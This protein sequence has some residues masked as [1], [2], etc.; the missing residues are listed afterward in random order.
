MADAVIVDDGG[1]T[2]IKQIKGTTANGK[3]DALLDKLQDTAKGPFT[4]LTISCIDPTG[5]SGPPT[6]ATAAT[7]PIAMVNN[8]T[9]KIFSGDH[10]VEGRI[11]AG[12]D[13]QITVSG[14]DNTEPVIEARHSKAK[15]QRRYVVSNAPTIDKVDVNAAGPVQTFTVPDGTVYTM[16]ILT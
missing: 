13:C 11:V 16:V 14:V 2:R 9:F 4:K 6:G 5:A 15:D 1:S 12:D 3:L 8:N 10:R 7:F